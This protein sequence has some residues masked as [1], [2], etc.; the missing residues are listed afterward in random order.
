MRVFSS[1]AVLLVLLGSIANGQQHDVSFEIVQPNLTPPANSAD[2]RYYAQA[3][4]R[5]GATTQSNSRN[6]KIEFV[7]SRSIEDDPIQPLPLLTSPDWE[8]Q[9]HAFFKLLLS[10]YCDRFSNSAILSFRPIF[11]SSLSVLGTLR[12]T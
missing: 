9:T 12:T 3:D 6:D 2:A 5:D 7:E 8:Q 4:T 10:G 11:Q 1:L